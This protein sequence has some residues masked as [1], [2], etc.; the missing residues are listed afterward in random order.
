MPAAPDGPRHPGCGKAMQV[1]R[2]CARVK[3]R[4]IS[5]FVCLSADFLAALVCSVVSCLMKESS[6][7]FK[8]LLLSLP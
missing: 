8:L 7:I 4:A 5:D 1:A 2:T 6:F 3:S